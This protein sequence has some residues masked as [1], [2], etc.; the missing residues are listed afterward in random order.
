[1]SY[2]MKE[3]SGSLF[4]NDRKEKEGHPDYTGTMLLNGEKFRISA[5]VNETKGGVKYFGLKFKPTAS[6][7]ASD[8]SD[9]LPF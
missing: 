6:T 4:K 8:N 7:P 3:A 1:M 5:W 2:E 9:G